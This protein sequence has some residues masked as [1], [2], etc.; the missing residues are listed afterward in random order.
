MTHSTCCLMRDAA[1][2]LLRFIQSL[3][4]YPLLCIH[5]LWPCSWCCSEQEVGVRTSQGHRHD[6][7]I[8]WSSESGSLSVS[9]L[10]HCHICK[11]IWLKLN[12]NKIFHCSLAQLG[13]N[14]FVFTMIKNT[15]RTVAHSQLTTMLSH[16][17]L[18]CTSTLHVPVNSRCLTW[19]A[20]KLLQGFHSLDWKLN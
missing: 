8:L 3:E 6:F 4:Y 13:L 11:E 14:N 2:K 20:L 18:S 16:Q 15:E 12:L 1:E 9:V 7:V 10:I 19:C 5:V 17:K